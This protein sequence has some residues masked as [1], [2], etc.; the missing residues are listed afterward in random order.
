MGFEY[1][2][3]SFLAEYKIDIRGRLGMR[4]V[5]QHFK[6]VRVEIQVETQEAVERL[7]EVVKE[8]EQRCPVYNLIQ[9]AGV[10]ITCQWIRV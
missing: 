10:D 8:T 3:L 4:G 7:E 1:N 6:I 5:T 2:K 9:N